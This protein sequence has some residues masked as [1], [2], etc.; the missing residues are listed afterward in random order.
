[1]CRPNKCCPHTHSAIHANHP[2]ISTQTLPLRVIPVHTHVLLTHTDTLPHSHQ[3]CSYIR[4]FIQIYPYV[5]SCPDEHKCHTT[6]TL[7]FYQGYFCVYTPPHHSQAMH[8][9]IS[10]LV[11]YILVVVCTH[12]HAPIHMYT[13]PPIR[14]YMVT[15]FLSSVCL[16]VY[17]HPHITITQ[18]HTHTHTAV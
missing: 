17:P 15:R 9:C 11:T 3:A 5:L 8:L 16:S 10:T 7:D 6:Q 13:R 12:V 1:M 14:A 18:T 2:R 4:I